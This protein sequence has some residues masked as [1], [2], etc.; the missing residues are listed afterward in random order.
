[1]TLDLKQEKGREILFRLVE[2][3]DIVWVCSHIPLNSPGIAILTVSR[4][5]NFIPGKMNDMGIGY[6][7]LRSI[8]P[9]IIHASVSG[10][11]F[12]AYQ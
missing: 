1:M 8:N 6:E 7:K 3:A 10:E 5:D 12:Q 9:S 4:V 2:R 11:L